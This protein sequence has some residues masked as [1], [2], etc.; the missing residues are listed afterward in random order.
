VSSDSESQTHLHPGAVRPQGIIDDILKFRE[1]NDA[2]EPSVNFTV[3]QTRDDP[4]D[5]NVLFPGQ[6][7][8]E[9]RSYIEQPSDNTLNGQT[10]FI[11]SPD[12][13]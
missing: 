11:R 12:T 13:S 10:S 2:L 7:R 4:I 5:V 1:G 6:I 3:Q 9:S 8:V